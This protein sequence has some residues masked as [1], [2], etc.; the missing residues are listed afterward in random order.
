MSALEH[1]HCSTAATEPPMRDPDKQQ[2]HT[3]LKILTQI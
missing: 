2:Q 3:Q 1:S